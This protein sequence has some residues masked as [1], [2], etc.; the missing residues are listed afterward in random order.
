MDVLITDNDPAV[1]SKGFAFIDKL[2]A[3]DVAK[4]KLTPDEA[5]TARGRITSVPGIEGFAKVDLVVEVRWRSFTL[6]SR[7]L[8]DE[9]GSILAD[10]V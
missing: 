5:V 7:Q 4:G 9:S 2:L 6:S 10:S 1:I 3:K 8:Q